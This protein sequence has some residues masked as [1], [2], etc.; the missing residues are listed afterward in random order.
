MTSLFVS[1]KVNDTKNNS[2]EML[3]NNSFYF[4][5]QMY[6]YLKIK[7][8]KYAFMDAKIQKKIIHLIMIRGLDIAEP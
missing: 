2:N 7:I 3:S 5:I 6:Q 8:K 1:S 4:K